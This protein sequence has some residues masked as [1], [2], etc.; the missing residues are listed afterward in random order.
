MSRDRL[1]G[2]KSGYANLD[3]PGA[4]ELGSVQHVD[5]SASLN[6]FLEE[7]TEIEDI[8]SLFQQNV[9]RIQD[10]HANVLDA[11]S[12]EQV[13]SINA[14]TDKLVSETFQLG[15]SIK[16]RLKSMNLANRKA[17]GGPGQA[18]IRKNKYQALQEKFVEAIKK[19]QAVEYES[20]NRYRERMERQYRIVKPDASEDEIDRVLDEDGGGQL[21]AQA[22][23]SSSRSTEAREVLKE[24]QNRHDDIKKIEK[25]I[26]E[27]ARL[28]EEMQ[29]LITLQDEMIQQID[30]N[31]GTTVNH[32]TEAN[33]QI[34]QAIVYARASRKKK[35][36][37]LIFFVVLI[38]VIAL[39]IYFT[40]FHKP[41]N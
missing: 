10:L 11:F 17:T 13:N 8:I 2:M 32:S 4:W 22:L 12:E 19:Y 40:Q 18:Q 14:Q 41:R 34:E 9:K 16:E 38:I 1:A 15:N 24:V 28:F 30:E 36:C 20:R 5:P 26:V 31:M 6:T 21:F 37:L 29:T 3:D 23:M 7:V 35:W 25:S 33:K 39:V 27:L